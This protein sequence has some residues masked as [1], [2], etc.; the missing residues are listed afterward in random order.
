ML[1]WT[2]APVP[3]VALALLVSVDPAVGV[4]GVSA[5]VTA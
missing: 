1:L 3:D 5:I 4:I 2:T